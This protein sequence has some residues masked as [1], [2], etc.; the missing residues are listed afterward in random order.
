MRF[1]F[2]HAPG[3]KWRVEIDT[4]PVYLSSATT[5][6]VKV[7]G[8]MRQLDSDIRLPLLGARFSP[9]DLLGPDSLLGHLSAGLTAA[10]PAEQTEVAGRPA[11][12]VRLHTS[13]EQSIFLGFDDATG[14]LMRV[15]N[16]DGYA[17]LDVEK[18]SQPDSLPD[19]LFE[20]DGPIGRFRGDE[21]ASDRQTLDARESR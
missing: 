4:E 7:D 11:W 17:L 8:Q 15:T 20:W 10:G 13:D 9:L 12:S 14:I 1:D 3:G 19:S 18:L 16:A 6:L 21:A 2:H 5:T